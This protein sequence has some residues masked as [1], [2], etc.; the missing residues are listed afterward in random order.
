MTVLRVGLLDSLGLVRVAHSGKGPGK[1]IQNISIKI[2]KH[3]PE[4]N[5]NPA[6]LEGKL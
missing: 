5:S 1:C 2:L 6:R 3:I 4:A